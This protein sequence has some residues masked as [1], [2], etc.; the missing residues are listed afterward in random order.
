MSAA[1]YL[2]VG[3]G[4]LSRHFQHYLELEA[5][6]W[7]RWRRSDGFPLDRALDGC[8]AVLLLVSDDA[9]EPFVARHARADG[10]PWVHCSGSVVSARAAGLHPLMAFSDELY[11]HRTYRRIP[12]VGERGRL[13]F[14]E[15]F[16]DLPN[17]HFQIDAEAKPVYHA[18]AS[19]A[20]NFSTLLWS[21]AFTD[22][23]DRL[24]LPASVLH[25]YLERITANLERSASPLTGP[26]ARGDAATVERHLGALDGDPYAGVYRAFVEAFGETARRSVR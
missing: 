12:F 4:R 13:T 1:P 3:D 7:R 6:P 9:I 18:L 16:P 26:L 15:I 21:K 10:P 11:D 24:G 2:L 25:P 20:G 8:R 19:M 23:E 14:A 17:P 22:F 5:I